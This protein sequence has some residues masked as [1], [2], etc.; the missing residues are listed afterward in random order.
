MVEAGDWLMERIKWNRD[1]LK[2][3]RY[4]DGHPLMKQ[5]LDDWAEGIASEAEREARGHN[6]DAKYETSSG[7]G[8]PGP[9]GF[10]GRRRASV[11][12]ANAEAMVDNQA[13]DR[14]VKVTLRS[15]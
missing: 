8:K 4:C 7:P 15:K 13:H 10:Q 9:P 1:G 12:T 6:H 3:L 2:K 5:Y 14:L 11:I